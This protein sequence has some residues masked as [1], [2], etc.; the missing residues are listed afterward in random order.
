M[1]VYQDTYLE[2][3]ENN[4]AT[5]EAQSKNETLA[6]LEPIKAIDEKKLFKANRPFFFVFVMKT[7]IVALG[8]IKDPLW[9]KTCKR[10]FS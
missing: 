8:R 7:H 3:S 4:A 1:A 9:C 10:Y 2:M 6:V 5:T